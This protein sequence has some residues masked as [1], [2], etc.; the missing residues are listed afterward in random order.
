VSL[1]LLDE[2]AKADSSLRTGILDAMAD[3]ESTLH[4]EPEFAGESREPGK[5]FLI[6]DPLSVM[7][8]VD[9]RKRTVVIVDAWVHATRR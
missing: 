3:V 2:C 7:Y 5:R 9:H 4:N 1:R 6:V 8:K